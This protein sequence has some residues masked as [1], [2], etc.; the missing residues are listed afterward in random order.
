MRSAP[1]SFACASAKEKALSLAGISEAKRMVEG[2]LQPGLNAIAMGTS[3]NVR[4]NYCRA[5]GKSAVSESTS[6]CDLSHLSSDGSPK[7]GA[8][9]PS[10]APCIK[11]HIS[12]KRCV[13]K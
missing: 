1:N 13:H 6:T 4:S 12:A 5:K 11:T 8:V 9:P 10:P 3:F 7:D 2:L